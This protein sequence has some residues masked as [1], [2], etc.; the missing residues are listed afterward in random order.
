MSQLYFNKASRGKT[1]QTKKG[2]SKRKGQDLDVNVDAAFDFKKVKIFIKFLR[3]YS[4]I[5]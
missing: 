5:T 4:A 1:K 2:E 3:L